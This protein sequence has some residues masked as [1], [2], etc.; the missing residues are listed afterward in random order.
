MKSKSMVLEKTRLTTQEMF[1]VVGGKRQHTQ[2]SEE[3]LDGGTLQ[4]VVIKP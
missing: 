1:S 2:A 4:E 3:T